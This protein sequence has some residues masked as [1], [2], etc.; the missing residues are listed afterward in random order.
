MGLTIITRPKSRRVGNREWK[1][2][3]RQL[4]SEMSDNKIPVE[5]F[6]VLTRSR[7]WLLQEVVGMSVCWQRSTKQKKL[8]NY[9]VSE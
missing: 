5:Q 8:R 4:N 6:P 2:R 7:V 3:E 9:E 1:K